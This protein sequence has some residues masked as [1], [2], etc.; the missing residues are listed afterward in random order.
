MKI[1]IDRIQKLK[2]G[3]FK[4]LDKYPTLLDFNVLNSYYY[5]IADL[6]IEEEKDEFSTF[7]FENCLTQDLKQ[8]NDLIFRLT[9]VEPP[10]TYDDFYYAFIL[11]NKCI[12]LL[13]KL[14]DEWIDIIIG[15]YENEAQNEGKPSE[16]NVDELKKEID[17][18]DLRKDFKCDKEQFAIILFPIQ[19]SLQK[20]F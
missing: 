3:F 20:W 18:Y 5:Q 12:E 8:F 1:N 19:F 7:V 13:E 14:K 9:R 15:I 6:E 17:K 16:Y 4:S 11:D 10:Y 2:N